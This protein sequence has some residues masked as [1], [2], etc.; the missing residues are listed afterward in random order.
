MKEVTKSTMTELQTFQ[1]REKN[2]YNLYHKQ[3]IPWVGDAVQLAEHLYGI[4]ETW[5]TIPST[6]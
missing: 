4:P 5:D 2:I 1:G 6:A 3:L